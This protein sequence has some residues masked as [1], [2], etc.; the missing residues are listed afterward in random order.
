M[1][2]FLMVVSGI[3]IYFMKNFKEEVIHPICK[4]ID[5][6]ILSLYREFQYSIKHNLSLPNTP[7]SIYKVCNLNYAMN[8]FSIMVYS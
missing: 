7:K 3:L 8:L 1:I 6:W 4:F 2:V 5:Y